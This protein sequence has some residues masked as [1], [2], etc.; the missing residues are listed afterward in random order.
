MLI[1]CPKCTTSY[2]IEP[3]TL[4]TGRVVRCSRCGEVWFAAPKVE[5]MAAAAAEPQM[6]SVPDTGTAAGENMRAT[7]DAP[8]A[9][10]PALSEAAL[11]EAGDSSDTADSAAPATDADIT[12][13]ALA[14][15]TDPAPD[16]VDAPPLV[17]SAGHAL[18]PGG[19]QGEADDIENFAARRQRLHDRRRK[20]RVNSRWTAIV[21]L[22]FA[23][24]VALIGA[25]AEVVRYLPQTASLFSA[26]GL[27]VNLRHLNFENVHIT[28]QTLNGMP[29]LVV[30]GTIAS[31]A[32]RAIE[33]PRLRFAARNAAG[34]EIYNWL[35]QPE[36][37]EL[38]PGEVLS[39]R[40]AL[41]SP[42][43]DIH[44]VMVRFLST[45]DA[46]GGK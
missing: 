39:F 36:R 38:G 22:L 3:A 45:S 30:E 44:D 8:G 12:D 14:P 9:A 41:A 40:S 21:L 32:N 25:R 26:I 28:R 18:L 1:A 2:A 43:Q 6:P 46:M 34:Q 10:D 42:P 7:P 19:T 20:R 33:V 37:K 24:N 17:P 29:M 13:P 11:G 5:V 31:I 35:L 15:S 4:G 16:R 27:P 23:A